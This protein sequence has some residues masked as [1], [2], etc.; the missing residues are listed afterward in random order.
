MRRSHSVQP[1][2]HP[3]AWL[4]VGSQRTSPT[5]RVLCPPMFARKSTKRLKCHRIQSFHEIC[6]ACHVPLSERVLTVVRRSL[7]PTDVYLSELVY[8]VIP[9]SGSRLRTTK[10]LSLRRFPIP[11]RLS[12]SC[13]LLSI[14]R[15]TGAPS[16]SSCA[17]TRLDRRGLVL[18]RDP[19]LNE[20]RFAFEAYLRNHGCFLPL[21]K[22]LGWRHAK[23]P[24]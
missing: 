21:K 17:C 7:C 10:S 13:L 24:R 8:R 20:M 16:S 5:L 11:V 19:G 3:Q 9:R 12:S 4:T 14:A 6:S 15:D 23:A 2:C 18:S 1:C 22:T